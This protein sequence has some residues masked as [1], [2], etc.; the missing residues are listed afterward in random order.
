MVK[1]YI[2]CDPEKKEEYREKAEAKKDIQQKRMYQVVDKVQDADFFFL[3]PEG[4]IQ[5][6]E[7]RKIEE[8]GL[9]IRHMTEDFL[10]VELR[11]AVL[12]NTLKLFG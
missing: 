4:R 10:W 6:T 11:E 9:T 2:C 5:E 12:D 7:N 1:V 3:M 8:K